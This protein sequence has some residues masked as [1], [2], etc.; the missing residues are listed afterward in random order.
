MR[1]KIENEGVKD[2]KLDFLDHP[3]YQNLMKL[4]IDYADGI[5]VETTN[6]DPIIAQHLAQSNKNVLPY[7]EKESAQYLDN[8]ENFY[9]Q[10]L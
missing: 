2:K 1:K 5:V 6:L 10:L 8:Y 4:V 3:S 7:V 9:D